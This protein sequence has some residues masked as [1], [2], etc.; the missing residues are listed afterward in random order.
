MQVKNKILE[1]LQKDGLV[2]KKLDNLFYFIS[3]TYNYSI[4]EVKKGFKKLEEE[5]KIYRERKDKYTVVPSKNFVRG[6]FIGNAKGFGFCEIDGSDNEDI[7]L[8]S[9]MT[10][11][12][13][14]G[15][16]II[17]RTLSQTEEGT[18]GQVVSIFR[19]VKRLV[20]VVEKIG[21]NYFL[22]PDNNHIPFKIRLIKGQI[23]INEDDRVV[24]NLIRH[25]DKFSGSVEEV[26]GKSDDV[27]ACELSII[28]D[29]G[30]Y[31]TFPQEV[32]NEALAL[33][34]EVLPSQKKGRLDL[35]NLV[36]FLY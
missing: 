1:V 17:V 11:N 31:E 36:T 14:D 8:P 4:D 20:G 9:N 7:F 28:R 34:Q 6:T 10:N 27:K 26:L 24:I 33:P 22:D 32:L 23:K 25:N 16:G 5:G 12:A 2:F 3:N 15:D 19:P 18:D 30:L 35:T 21:S 13:I 29:H